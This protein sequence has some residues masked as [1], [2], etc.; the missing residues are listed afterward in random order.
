MEGVSGGGGGGVK[1]RRGGGEAGRRRGR[2][3]GGEA[4]QGGGLAYAASSAIARV[5]FVCVHPPSE[6]LHCQSLAHALL[7]FK[8]KYINNTLIQGPLMLRPSLRSIPE[9]QTQCAPCSSSSSSSSTFPPP[10]PPLTP[11][12]PPP[13]MMTRCSE[14]LA[15]QGPLL[16]RPPQIATG[17]FEELTP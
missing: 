7:S 5:S 13:H 4:G 14:E 11:P 15:P 8:I 6:S 16:A 3:A 17:C 1:R 12:P 9:Y 2:E 10:P